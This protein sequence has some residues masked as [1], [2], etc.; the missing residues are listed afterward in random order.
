[1]Q[2]P[3]HR[4]GQRW[5]V[6]GRLVADN[7]PRRRPAGGNG[8]LEESACGDH[9]ARRRHTGIDDLAV[10]V[11]RAVD[12]MPAAAY[13][14]VDLVHSPVRTYGVAVLASHLAERRQKALHPAIDRALIDQDSA[15]GQ[16]FT[17]FGVA[18]AITH[19]PADGQGNDVVRKAA[20]PRTPNSSVG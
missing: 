19:I 20:G 18:E 14:S 13:S 12:V 5:R 6:G 2:H 10:S 9:V 16:P 15:L 7:P 11:D 4:R 1:M 8:M 3:W 17:D